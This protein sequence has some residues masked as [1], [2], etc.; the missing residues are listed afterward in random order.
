[1]A[2]KNQDKSIRFMYTNKPPI[3]TRHALINQ[4][5]NACPS[6]RGNLRREAVRLWRVSPLDESTSAALPSQHKPALTSLVSLVVTKIQFPGHKPVTSAPHLPAMT[7]GFGRTVLVGLVIFACLVA[8]GI[9]LL[10]HAPRVLKNHEPTPAAPA[11]VWLDFVDADYAPQRLFAAAPALCLH[12][13]AT[14]LPFIETPEEA[15]QAQLDTEKIG[16]DS[17]EEITALRWQEELLRPRPLTPN[18]GK[19]KYKLSPSF[20]FD[21]NEL[22]LSGMTLR[23]WFDF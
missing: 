4:P 8:P 9:F 12:Y 2:A 3:L 13:G 15:Y 6:I 16:T 19:L 10:R 1:M 22:K 21:N 14:R 18:K 5:L 20:S 7:E 17:A 23:V 11:D